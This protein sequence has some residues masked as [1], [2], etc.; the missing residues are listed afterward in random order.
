MVPFLRMLSQRG[1]ATNKIE[2]FFVNPSF[3]PKRLIKVHK[4]CIFLFSYT[5]N[6][7]ILTEKRHY[8]AV[9]IADETSQ[10]TEIKMSFMEKL[11][12]YDLPA[13]F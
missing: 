3:G 4:I 11:G 5:F 10:I 1:N 12:K 6:L 7:S 9:I 13:G 8:K 2:F